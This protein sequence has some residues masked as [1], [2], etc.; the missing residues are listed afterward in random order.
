MTHSL[1]VSGL[2][3]NTQSCLDLSMNNICVMAV[4]GKVCVLLSDAGWI[5]KGVGSKDR[6]SNIYR[7]MENQ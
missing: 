7:T 4:T 5:K 2:T 3:Q 6:K 1:D